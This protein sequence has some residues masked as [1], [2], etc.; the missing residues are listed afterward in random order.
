MPRVFRQRPYADIAIPLSPT[1]A[2]SASAAVQ[3]NLVGDAAADSIAINACA[4]QR[5]MRTRALGYIRDS[6][7][8]PAGIAEKRVIVAPYRI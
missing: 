6:N 3:Y 1:A 5:L 8:R 4:H 7:R 2:V